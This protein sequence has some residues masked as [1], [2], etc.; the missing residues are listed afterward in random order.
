M[1]IY[2]DIDHRGFR[3]ALEADQAKHGVKGGYEL[4]E[5]VVDEFQQKIDDLIDIRVVDAATSSS[6]QG[7][8]VV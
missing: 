5:T 3:Q 6:A 2:I 4:D 1:N 8:V 7:A